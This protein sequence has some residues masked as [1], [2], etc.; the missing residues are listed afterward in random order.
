[1]SD[2]GLVFGLIGCFV[3]L[4]NKTDFLSFLEHLNM[5]LSYENFA[6]AKM[7]HEKKYL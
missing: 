7:T 3:L 4:N 2:R 1:L 5:M 6:S